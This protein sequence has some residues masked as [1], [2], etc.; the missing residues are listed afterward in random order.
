MV[1]KIENIF[2]NYQKTKDITIKA[3]EFINSNLSMNARAHE[4]TDIYEK[5]ISRANNV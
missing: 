5:V 2:E 1:A 4:Y 3:K